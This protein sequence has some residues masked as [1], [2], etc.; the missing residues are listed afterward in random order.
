M[1]NSCSHDLF[2]ACGK[3]PKQILLLYHDF[4][5]MYFYRVRPI[6]ILLLES[7]SLSCHLIDAQM[8]NHGMSN[9]GCIGNDVCYY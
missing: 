1:V 7:N 9:V 6:N 4:F 8:P 2:L 3:L 5:K